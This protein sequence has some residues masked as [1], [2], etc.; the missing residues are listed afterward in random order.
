MAKRRVSGASADPEGAHHRERT[1]Y[2][3]PR[4]PAHPAH[5][6]SPRPVCGVAVPVDGLGEFGRPDLVQPE[7]A[8]AWTVRLPRAHGCWARLRRSRPTRTPAVPQRLRGVQPAGATPTRKSSNLVEVLG[9][10]HKQG[11]VSQMRVYGDALAFVG[12][13]GRTGPG[14]AAAVVRGCSS[15]GHSA[16][17]SASRCRRR[18]PRNCLPRDREDGSRRSRGEQ[19]PRREI[20]RLRWPCGR[21][22]PRMEDDHCRGADQC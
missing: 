12:R 2:R 7:S 20:G 22:S 3:G 9:C 21:I 6:S 11:H 1:T 18:R 16:A 10:D 15:S 13:G 8:L 19:P 14:S 4:Q 17:N 5:P